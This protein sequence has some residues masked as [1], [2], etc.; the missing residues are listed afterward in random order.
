MPAV[1]DAQKHEACM[2]LAYKRHGAGALRDV[3]NKGPVI[4]M[5][6]SMTEEELREFCLPAV[7]K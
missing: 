3:K 5:A 1:S 2:A 7:K 4:K 6:N